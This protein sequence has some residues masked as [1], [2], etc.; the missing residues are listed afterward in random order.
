MCTIIRMQLYM[1]EI[2]VNIL[3]SLYT[4]NEPLNPI[5]DYHISTVVKVVNADLQF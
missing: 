4:E 5:P 3:Y 2:S 1:K